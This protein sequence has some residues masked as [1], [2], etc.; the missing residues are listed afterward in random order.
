MGLK[1]WRSKGYR[2][3]I[4]RQPCLKCGRTPCD[5]HHVSFAN[6]GI[7]TKPPDSYC[8]PLCRECHTATHGDKFF[9]VC[10]ELYPAVVFGE[11]VRNL[12]NWLMLED[13]RRLY[14][15]DRG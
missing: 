2:D 14:K 4:R 1:P 10:A 12:T 7:G 5:P 3:Y 15:K 13:E 6:T 8:I 11:I 9:I